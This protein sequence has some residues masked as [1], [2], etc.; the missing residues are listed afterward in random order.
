MNI[1]LTGKKA[2]VCG[3]TQGIAKP[4]PLNWRIWERQSFCW[5]EMRFIATSQG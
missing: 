5:H 3:S 1:N 4:L 2:F